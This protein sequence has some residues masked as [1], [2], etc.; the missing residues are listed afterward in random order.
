MVAARLAA[1]ACRDSVFCPGVGRCADRAARRPAAGD[2][3]R[4]D[5]RRVD[6]VLSRRAAEALRAMVG[7][8]GEGH[9]DL[10]RLPTGAAILQLARGLTQ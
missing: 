1:P 3:R 5:V 4:F 9:R 10:V 6:Y 7:A 2:R 8:L